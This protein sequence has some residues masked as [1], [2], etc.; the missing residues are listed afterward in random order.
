[1]KKI[2]SILIIIALSF[3]AGCSW[4]LYKREKDESKPRDEGTETKLRWKGPKAAIE[5][6]F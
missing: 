3:T 2:I 5:H 6:K 1:M 4:T